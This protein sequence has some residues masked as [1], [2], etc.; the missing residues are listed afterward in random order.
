[1]AAIRGQ[2]MTKEPLPS[3]FFSFR[4]LSERRCGPAQNVG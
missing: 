2:G 1:V 4:Y 3:R